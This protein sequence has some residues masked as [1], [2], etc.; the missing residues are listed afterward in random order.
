MRGWTGISKWRRG[1]IRLFKTFVTAE[2]YTHFPFINS[3]VSQ[4]G[5]SST[6]AALEDDNHRWQLLRDKRR[7]EAAQSDLWGSSSGC[8]DKKLLGVGQKDTAHHCESE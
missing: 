3:P 7:T 6:K 5:S 2:L 1:G 8:R 4:P